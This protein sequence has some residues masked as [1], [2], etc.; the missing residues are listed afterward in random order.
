MTDNHS[1]LRASFSSPP[2]TTYVYIPAL[3]YSTLDV[4]TVLEG[5]NA[6][7]ATYV[8]ACGPTVGRILTNLLLS[9]LFFAGYSAITVTTRVGF[10]MA[11]DDAFPGSS[12]LQVVN[13][14]QQVPLRC[15]LMVTVLHVLLLLLPLA[16]P[17]AFSAITSICTIGFQISY[18]MPIV[19]VSTL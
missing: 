5:S 11:R 10:A 16:Q 12:W 6:A 19:L 1:S 13:P 17:L 4:D 7:V 15:L 9:N 14:T 3:L 8:M 2:F 18:A